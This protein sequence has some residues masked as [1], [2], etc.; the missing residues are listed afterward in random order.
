MNDQV[1]DSPDGLEEPGTSQAPADSQTQTGD[2][3]HS[4]AAEDVV[5]AIEENPAVKEAIRRMFQSEK[6]KGVDKAQKMADE[7]RTLIQRVLEIAGVDPATAQNAE[8]QAHLEQMVEAWQQGDFSPPSQV[9][10]SGLTP[11]EAQTLASSLTSG[12]L[13][14]AK[15]AVLNQVGQNAFPTA[16]AL[17]K[18]VVTQSVAVSSKPVSTSASAATPSAGSAASPGIEEATAHFMKT[19]Q[20]A[21]DKGDPYEAKR[22]R[23]E[24]RANGIPFD[25]IQWEVR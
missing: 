14:E 22:L 7:N 21:L 25:Q 3:V 20:A 1:T 6:D 24:A 23:K 10:G 4:L 16:E 18:F 9:V 8:Q 15:Q 17:T 5:K 2:A 19:Y 11:D 12:L 13:P